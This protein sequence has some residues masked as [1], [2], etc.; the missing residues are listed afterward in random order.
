[1]PKLDFRRRHA[2][3][4]GSL[5]STVVVCTTLERPDPETVS[6]IVNRPGVFKVHGRV[7][8]VTG[9]EVLN[10]KGVFNTTK[11]PTVEVIVRV[12]P[13]C[14]VDMNHWCYVTE[15]FSS[16][17]AKVQTVEDLVGAGRWLRLLCT[18]EEI[19]DIRSDPATQPMHP[20]WER[21]AEAPL[22]FD[23]GF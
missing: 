7:R 12:P 3:E 22:P 20:A 17:W 4:L 2:P 15:R 14:K 21:P 18:R 13:D 1:M 16:F 9:E 10:Y 6:T 8:S 23:D 5:R 11:V 19:L